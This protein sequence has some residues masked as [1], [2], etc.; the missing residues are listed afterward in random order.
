MARIPTSLIRKAHLV[1][2]IPLLRAGVRQGDAAHA[3]T[4]PGERSYGNGE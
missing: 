1:P 2:G 3:V 4:G